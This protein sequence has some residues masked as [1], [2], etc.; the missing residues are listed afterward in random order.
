MDR[1]LLSANAESKPWTWDRKRET[2]EAEEEEAPR[3]V[4]TDFEVIIWT[5]KYKNSE[6]G[7]LSFEAVNLFYDWQIC[8]IEAGAEGPYMFMNIFCEAIDI[9][10]N[11]TH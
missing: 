6:R 4:H 11:K 7:E 3:N 2:E 9:E 10:T 8:K 5:Q 1:I